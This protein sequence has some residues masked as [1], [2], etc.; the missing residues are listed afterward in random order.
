MKLSFLLLLFS[1]FSLTQVNNF[2][3][4]DNKLVWENV[5]ITNEANIPELI[6][7]H[8][9]LELTNTSGNIYKGTGSR[10]KNACPGRLNYMEDGLSF[11]YEIE[12]KNGMYRVTVTN[13]YLTGNDVPVGN[14]KQ[15][16]AEKYFLDNKPIKKL[17]GNS[18]DLKCLDMFF[19]RLFTMTNVYRNKS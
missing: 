15:I 7:R 16:A 8:P 10:I 1:V 17:S 14:P 11:E 5:I 6:A 12:Q 19:N 2:T 18:E 3:V 13:L 9:R 4:K